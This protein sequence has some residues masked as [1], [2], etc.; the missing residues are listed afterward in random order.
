MA[1]L[2]GKRR[3]QGNRIR[4]YMHKHTTC[5]AVAADTCRLHDM[6]IFDT[7]ERMF[8]SRASRWNSK[9]SPCFPSLYR[10]RG[11]GVDFNPEGSLAAHGTHVF[12]GNGCAG[13]PGRVA[14][15]SPGSDRL[16]DIWANSGLR[17]PPLEDPHCKTLAGQ[18]FWGLR[19]TRPT[20]A[21]PCV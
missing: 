13:E 20:S 16:V 18:A 10:W 1:R 4:T 19:L 14:V 8:K 17:S 2:R 12:I 15:G 11:F 7:P 21:L 9:S 6:A 3:P 5:A